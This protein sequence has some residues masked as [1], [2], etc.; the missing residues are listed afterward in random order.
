MILKK[1]WFLIARSIQLICCCCL[2]GLSTG[3][4]ILWR[5]QRPTKN[6]FLVKMKKSV[7]SWGLGIW[8]SSTSFLKNNIGWPQQPPSERVPYFSEKLDFWWPFHKKWPVLV[9]LVPLMISLS[10]S[11][12]FFWVNMA[13]GA[14]EA[15]EVAEA[16]KVNEAAEVFKVWKKH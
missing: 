13:V 11:V 1:S 3:F 5:P 16:A 10:G 12:F 9:I 8:V 15:I 4:D 14:V 7:Y 2:Q 6:T